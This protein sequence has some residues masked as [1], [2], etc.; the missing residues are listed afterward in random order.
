MCFLRSWTV[1][2]N[3]WVKPV[4]VRLWSQK[5][6]ST[7]KTIVEGCSWPKKLG[8]WVQKLRQ[9][10]NWPIK[11]WELKIENVVVCVFSKNYN[12]KYLPQS[13]TYVINVSQLKSFSQMSKSFSSLLL[14]YYK[15]KSG[16]SGRLWSQTFFRRKNKFTT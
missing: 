15:Q 13:I 9:W 12:F 10:R 2:Q 4:Y 7:Q 16:K 11:I 5:F 3:L 1:Y 6:S 14:Y 8:A